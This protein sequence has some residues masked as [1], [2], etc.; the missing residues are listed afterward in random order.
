M[1]LLSA[2][3]VITNLEQIFAPNRLP[4]NLYCVGGEVKHC[5]ACSKSSIQTEENREQLPETKLII[6]KSIVSY[7]VIDN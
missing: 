4:Y 1:L 2:D 7:A 3:P 6:F 5:S